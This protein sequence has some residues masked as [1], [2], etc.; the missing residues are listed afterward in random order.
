MSLRPFLDL[1]VYDFTAEFWV[2]IYIFK[3]RFH[4]FKKSKW[5]QVCSDDNMALDASIHYHEQ[6]KNQKPNGYILGYTLAAVTQN[7]R[8]P[9]SFLG[10]TANM[11]SMDETTYRTEGQRG[12][13]T[14]PGECPW[15]PTRSRMVPGTEAATAK[16]TDQVSRGLNRE[17]E[18]WCES[19]GSVSSKGN[20]LGGEVNRVGAGLRTSGQMQLG[21]VWWRADTAGEISHVQRAGE[22]GNG[23]R[24]EHE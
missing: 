7:I 10:D 21:Q 9:N 6:V 4:F 1:L 16:G 15:A 3:F 2:K 22:T 5:G 13:P 8:P 12:T 20:D 23:A 17:K 14:T 18:V 19:W 11:V 24:P